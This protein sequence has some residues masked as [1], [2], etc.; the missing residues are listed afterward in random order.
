[1]EE[2]IDYRIHETEQLRSEL[3][4]LENQ[5]LTLTG[6][7]LDYK[8][9]RLENP[10]LLDKV[11]DLLIDRQFILDV[12]FERHC[13]QDDISRIEKINDLL[14]DMTN[15]TYARTANLYRTLLSMP[16][17]ELDDDYELEGT[18]TPDFDLPYSILRLEDDK[19]YGSDFVRMAAILK[20]TEKDNYGMVWAYCCTGV[21]DEHTPNMTDQEL[22]CANVLDDGTNWSEGLSLAEKKL[23]HITMCFALHAMW[24]HMH[25]SMP[26]I[27]RFN[28]FKIEVTMKVQQFSDQERHRLWWW[29][30]YDLLQFKE[31]LLHQAKTR[32]AGMSEADFILLRARDYFEQD[33]DVALNKAGIDSIDY[34][35]NTLYTVLQNP[36]EYDFSGLNS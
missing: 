6:D 5:I 18:L 10:D 27:I 31:V 13:T 1:M 12:L 16:R 24:T 4:A 19:W 22:D 30:K 33:A 11:R 36:P 14:L 23:G 17:E 34:Y 9:R 25:Y 21:D 8:N 20:E 35:L 3:K 26:D 15:R 29:K 32:P 2:I 28:D 7:P